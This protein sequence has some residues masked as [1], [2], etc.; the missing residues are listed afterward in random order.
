[1]HQQIVGAVVHEVGR[2]VPE[3][4]RGKCNVKLGADAV[5]GRRH[6]P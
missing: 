4:V 1:M 5:H 2:G 3:P 6:E